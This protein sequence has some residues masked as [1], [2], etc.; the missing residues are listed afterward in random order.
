MGGT[1]VDGT[2]G[3]VVEYGVDLVKEPVVYLEE[4]LGEAELVYELAKFVAI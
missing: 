1:Y 3:V 2:V 4:V